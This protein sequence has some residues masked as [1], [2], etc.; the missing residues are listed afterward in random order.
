MR[1]IGK[2]FAKPLSKAFLLGETKNSMAEPAFSVVTGAFGYTGKYIAQR[3][4]DQGQTVRCLTRNPASFSPFGD[5]VARHPLDFDDT[6]QL[7]R[8]LEGADTLYNTFWIRFSRGPV[9]HDL[10]V[11]NTKNLV[12]AAVTA[13]VR[14]IVHI[15]I[16]GASTDSPLP[17]FRGKGEV[18][19][20]IKESGLDYSIVR[21]T[22]I[23]GV[24]DILINNIAWFLRRFPVF[25]VAGRG[26]YP[27]QPVFVDDVARLAVE[28]A[29]GADSVSLDAVGPETFTFREMVQQIR[30]TAGGRAM[31]VS[32][33]PPLVLASAQMAGFLVR[34][35]VLTRE[36]IDGLMSGHLISEGPPTAQTR[37]TDWMRDHRHTLGRHYASELARHYR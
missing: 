26:E 27:L 2:V 10:A 7:A 5:R 31:V 29:S 11:Q 36:E 21:P 28:S 18:E 14:R 30:R 20:Y 3:L 34:D 8:S 32:L 23:F 19:S 22:V 33:P 17:Y 4:L 35:V 6:E 37:L 25:P 9:N 12:D 13:G 1:I 16:T 15:S 24:E